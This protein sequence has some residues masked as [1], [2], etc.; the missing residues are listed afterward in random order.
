M[1]FF[2]HGLIILDGAHQ[3]MVQWRDHAK[4]NGTMFRI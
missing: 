3:S 1:Q 2:K 4:E